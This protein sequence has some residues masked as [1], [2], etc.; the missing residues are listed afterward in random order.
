M[1]LKS[2]VSEFESKL[3]ELYSLMRSEGTELSDYLKNLINE[4]QELGM[5]IFKET[6]GKIIRTPKKE[7][8]VDEKVLEVCKIFALLKYGGGQY[9]SALD[10]MKEYMRGDQDL[11]SVILTIEL[12]EELL[13]LRGFD[14]D[15]FMG[16]KFEIEGIYVKDPIKLNKI[17]EKH[18]DE[19]VNCYIYGNFL[20]GMGMCRAILERAF[21]EKYQVRFSSSYTLAHFINNVWEKHFRPH[22]KER[23]IELK[24]KGNEIL[25]AARYTLHSSDKDWIEFY[26]HSSRLKE[27]LGSVK[28]IL[29]Y[30]FG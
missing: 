22:E 23:K 11:D 2:T 18:F 30:L 9:C 8:S 14:P 19:A 15:G 13:S 28:E 10:Y 16:R 1:N 25:S 12:I 24:G 26:H 21:E 17:V 6:H 3:E 29:E 27:N 5:R 4:L 7:L 20:A